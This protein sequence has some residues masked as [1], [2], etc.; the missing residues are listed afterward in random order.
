M[1]VAPPI[2][3]TLVVAAFTVVMYM[4]YQAIEIIPLHII[5]VVHHYTVGGHIYIAF[6]TLCIAWTWLAT[7]IYALEML[8]TTYNEMNASQVRKPL[9]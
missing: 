4:A 6:I 1:P 3:I 2:I 9:L 5:W 7:T 8:Y